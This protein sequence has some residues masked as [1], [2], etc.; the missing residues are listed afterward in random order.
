MKDK[1]LGILLTVV[2]ILSMFT[3]YSCEDNREYDE[4]QVKAAAEEL[5]KKSVALNEIYYGKGISYVKD[6]SLAVG[7]YYPADNNSLM[8]YNIET[9]DDLLK[10][11]K[12]VF[13]TEMSTLIYDTKLTPLFDSDGVMRGY[14][15]YYQKYTES[16]KSKP[17]CILVYK[18]AIVLLNDKIT[19]KYDTLKVKESRGETVYVTIEVFVEKDDGKSQTKTLEIGLIEEEMGWRLSSPTYTSYVDL[20]YY[21]QLQ[22]KNQK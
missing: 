4:I 12:E 2:V 20:D 10:K 17:E 5:I 15:R 21:N 7:P 3:L 6:D 14:S 11:T 18:D 19:Y 8:G 1:I 13:S 9:V 16:D 22:N